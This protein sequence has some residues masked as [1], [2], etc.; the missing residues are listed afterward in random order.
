MTGAYDREATMA[1]LTRAL[2]Y[3]RLYKGRVFVIKLGG[4]LGSDAAA[5]RQVAEQ[6]SVLREV[7]IRVVLVHGGG[8]QT[9]AL[10]E[11]LG[12]EARFVNGRRVTSPE[13]L[14]AAVMTLN[15][16]INTSVLAA[17]RA[18][19]LPTVGISGVDA[20][21]LRA[22]VRPPVEMDLGQGPVTVDF[23]EV[24][25]LVSVDRSVPERLLAAGFVPVVSPIS[26]DDDG[27]LLNVNA[28][29]VAA[30]IA[31]ALDAEKLIFLTETPGILEDRNDPHSMISF[32]D[33]AGRAAM[34]A[35]G[36]LAGGMLP[37][38]NSARAALFGGVRRVHIVGFRQRLSLLVEVFTNEGA[39]TLIVKD[40]AE[41]PP[42]EQGRE[43][44]A[45]A[46]STAP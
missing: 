14:E 46:G 26:A 35:R 12:V 31:C 22:R 18:V 36:A 3:I 33:L 45:D 44:Q 15:G 27:R 23:G 32:T 10:G 29:T 34:E 25:D 38:V 7:G 40:V 28:D 1:G 24:G 8:P 9:T 13:A 4:V 11:R 42:I 19:H 41:L 20:G 5:L 30:T 39:G 21:L 16:S 2:P 6:V 43:E 17:C 37:K